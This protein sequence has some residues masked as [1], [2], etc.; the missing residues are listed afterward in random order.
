MKNFTEYGYNGANFSEAMKAAL[1]AEPEVYIPGGNY[2]LDEPLI[3]PSNRKIVAAPDAVIKAAD[4]CFTGDDYRACVSN[5]YNEPVSRN[6]S[7]EGGVW[8]GNNASNARDDWRHG[9][10]T[11]VLVGFYG[12]SG[13]HISN[14]T[15]KNSETYH[16]IL[17]RVTDFTIENVVISDENKSLCQDGIHVGGGCS[18]G[19]IRNIIA[20]N[21]ATND[22]LIA[23]NADDAFDYRHNHYLFPEEIS[24]ITVDNV[25]AE[26]C[27]TAVRMLSVEAPIRNVTINNLAAGVREMGL[28]FD[29]TRYAGDRIFDPAN[30]PDGVGHI[31]NVRFKN[32]LLWKT[33][34]KDTP[35]CVIESNCRGVGFENFRRDLSRDV[36]PGEPFFRFDD[37]AKT[38]VCA[39]GET[40]GLACGERKTLDGGAYK[41]ITVDRN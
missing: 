11:G 6:I 9:P 36:L 34:D 15:V 37:L 26:N 19:V 24:D 20:E 14:V 4:G 8:D 21:G 35:L 23:F 2:T 18:R 12:V 5:D 10:C 32:V 28:N 29:A 16:F 31:E 30:Y 3:I 1:A 7:I 25:I 41:K 38:A 17:S 13:L 39:D 40:I 27:W 33:R 22:D